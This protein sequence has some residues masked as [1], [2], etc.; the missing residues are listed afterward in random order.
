MITPTTHTHGQALKH[1]IPRRR[2]II[3]ITKR[4]TPMA[5][6][7]PPSPTM[8]RMAPPMIPPIIASNPPIIQ[9]TPRM[10][11]PNGLSDIAVHLSGDTYVLPFVRN[12]KPGFIVE[13]RKFPV[14][15]HKRS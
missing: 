14:T 11:T 8:L 1:P 13:N 4:V 5:A 3:P 9:R 2:S 15:A 6:P 10:V 7:R 12:E